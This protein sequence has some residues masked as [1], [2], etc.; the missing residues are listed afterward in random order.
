MELLKIS[1]TEIEKVLT[2]AGADTLTEL[3][4]DQAETTIKWL[5]NK[6]TGKDGK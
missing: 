4:G 5:N 3:S 2:K 1:E 6:I